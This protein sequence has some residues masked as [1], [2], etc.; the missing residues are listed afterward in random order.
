M[1]HHSITWFMQLANDMGVVENS[2]VGYEEMQVK[3]TEQQ[4][5]SSTS[6]TDGRDNRNSMSCVSQR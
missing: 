6:A 5:R 3:F 2:T 1:Q 4:S